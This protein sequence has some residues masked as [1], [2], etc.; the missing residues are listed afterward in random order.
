MGN[1][2]IRRDPGY[3]DLGTALDILL[4]PLVLPRISLELEL[5]EPASLGTKPESGAVVL[6]VFHACSWSHVAATVRTLV[7][8]DQRCPL[9]AGASSLPSRFLEESRYLRF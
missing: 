6:D 8:D 1:L 2:D 4:G 5:A 9:S 7:L 3:S